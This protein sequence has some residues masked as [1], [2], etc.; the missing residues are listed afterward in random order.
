MNLSQ[1]IHLQET[2]KSGEQL[3]T[4]SVDGLCIS[5]SQDNFDKNDKNN[6]SGTSKLAER[7]KKKS[8]YSV[9]YP[10]Y[11]SRTE[12]FKKLFKEVPDD[13]RLVVGKYKHSIFLFILT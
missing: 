2:S 5:K 12:D 8:W 4:Q 7:A 1:S 9:L 10:S 13:E 11:K 6:K 3:S